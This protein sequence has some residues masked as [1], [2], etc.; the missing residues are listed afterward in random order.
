MKT[1]YAPEIIYWNEYF[2]M[3]TSSGR[4]GNHVLK[5]DSPT[6]PFS[7]VTKNIEKSIEGN[8]FIDDASLYLSH[9][10]A[11][12]IAVSPMID[13][14]T[15]AKVLLP[16]HLRIDLPSFKKMVNTT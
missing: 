2:Y 10:R 11:S 7:L 4:S 1:D 15:F 9:S 3:Y 14:V 12:G 6:G 13:P 5:S 16:A 8:I